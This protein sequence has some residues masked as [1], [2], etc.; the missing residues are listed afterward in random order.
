MEVYVTS[1]FSY[2]STLRDIQISRDSI[3][4]EPLEFSLVKIN[5]DGSSR[6]NL[7][8][9]GIGIFLRNHLGEVLTF[10]AAPISYGTN[11][12]EEAYAL[13][14][15]LI[16]AKRMSLSCLHIEGDS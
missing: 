12:M 4:R 5:F 13:L 10:Y 16:L 2:V 1:Y 8:E 6:G 11:N 14:E 9:S 3:K 15:G 7:G